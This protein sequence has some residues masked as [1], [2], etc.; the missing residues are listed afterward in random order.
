[1]HAMISLYQDGYY[2]VHCTLCPLTFNALAVVPCRIA[3]STGPVSIEEGST[4]SSE[5]IGV[6]S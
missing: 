2:R 1:M 5:D 6:V 4:G 3:D